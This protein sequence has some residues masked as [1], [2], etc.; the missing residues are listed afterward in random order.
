MSEANKPHEEAVLPKD[1]DGVAKGDTPLRITD[2]TAELDDA[3]PVEAKPLL[4]RRVDRTAKRSLADTP[5]FVCY[6]IQRFIE[7]RGLQTASSLT[8]TS[9]LGLVPIIAVFLAILSAF[10]ALEGAREQVKE[11]ILAPLVPGAGETVRN[12]LETF[13]DNAKSLGTMGV[14]GIAVTSILMLNTIESTLNGIWRVALRRP[15]GLK[16]IVFWALLTLPPLLI[17]ASLSLPSYFF[18]MANRVDVFGIVDIMEQVTPFLMHAVAFTFL[19]AATPNRR[20]R[21]RDALRG[22]LVASLL[23][24]CLKAG[25]GFY[26]ASATSNQTIYGALAVIPVFLLWIYLSWTVIL[27][28]AEVAAALPEWRGALAAEQRRR[29]TSGERLVAAVGILKVLWRASLEGRAVDRDDIESVLRGSTADLG[30]VVGRLVQ[31]NHVVVTENG[32]L[33]LTSDLDEVS[34]YALQRELGLALEETEQFRDAIVNEAPDLNV[35]ELAVLMAEAE[36]AKAK[37]MARSIKRLADH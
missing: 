19:F 29:L 28:G 11:M 32:G 36:A 5:A 12:A 25:F 30:A 13:L 7:D 3:V 22:G 2:G 14:I 35:P 37:I 18:H 33:A 26:V 16:L 24:G 21:I 17:A 4:R 27:I 20:V 23:F 8:Y 10:P 15:L 9:L 1:A 6:V 31:L 34:L